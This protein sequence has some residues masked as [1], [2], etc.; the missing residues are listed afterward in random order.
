MLYRQRIHQE[1]GDSSSSL[2]PGSNDTAAPVLVRSPLHLSDASTHQTGR[3]LTMATLTTRRRSV[4]AALACFSTLALNVSVVDAMVFSNPKTGTRREAATAD[5]SSLDRAMALRQTKQKGG[6]NVSEHVRS[7]MSTMDGDAWMSALFDDAAPSSSLGDTLPPN[8][9]V[10]ATSILGRNKDDNVTGQISAAEELDRIREVASFAKESR[11]ARGADVNAEEKMRLSAVTRR[12]AASAASTIKKPK[13]APKLKL[14]NTKKVADTGTK[15]VV[16]K[17]KK[18]STLLTR[19]Q[20]YALARVIQRGVEIHKLR[21]DY[22][23]ANSSSL[24]KREW[25]TLAGLDTPNDLR[26]VVA[27]YRDA[28]RE[29]VS[30]NVGLVHAVARQNSYRA[31]RTG[32]SYEELVQEGSLGLI[33]AAELFDPERGL[34]FSTYATIW[35]K[36]V[37]SNNNLDEVIILPTRE[38][39]KWNKIRNAIKDLSSMQ[40]GKKTKTKGNDEGKIPSAEELA[41]FLGMKTSE[42]ENTLRRMQKTRNV[43]SLDYQYQASTRSGYS[44]GGTSQLLDTTKLDIDDTDA[45]LAEHARLRAD[46]VTTL[47]RNLTEKEARLMRLRYGLTDDRGQEC[48]MKECAEIMGINRETARLLAKACLK[49]LREASDAESLQEYLM[50]IA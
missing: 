13:S 20:E 48:T 29:L 28:K 37:L 10:K 43:L 23:S 49:K 4:V 15:S 21:D 38:K 27:E 31:A 35:I 5:L 41:K 34:R 33:R 19:E 26:R 42:V 8:L 50:T 32:V 9:T 6:V 12:A 36:G 1:G 3:Q 45:D 39:N 17:K 16:V 2:P 30:S 25:A 7:A 14:K 44:E 24:S 11:I 18:S 40:Q 46:V 47:T 22:E